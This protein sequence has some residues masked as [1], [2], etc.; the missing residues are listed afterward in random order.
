MQINTIV[1]YMLFA[2]SLCTCIFI[3]SGVKYFHGCLSETIALLIKSFDQFRTTTPNFRVLFYHNTTAHSPL[4][5]IVGIAV[6]RRTI[7]RLKIKA[8]LPQN[9]FLNSFDTG[10]SVSF[11]CFQ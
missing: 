9:G 6:P 2:S 7:R 10:I 11:Y 1:I 4:I 3:Y 8:A 5:V